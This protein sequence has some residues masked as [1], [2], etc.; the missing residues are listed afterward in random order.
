MNVIKTAVAR[1]FASKPPRR[2]ARRMLDT[3][4]DFT[5]RATNDA[6]G[7]IRVQ[8]SPS[9]VDDTWF[10]PVANV[11]PTDM[12]VRWRMWNATAT[13]EIHEN[14]TKTQMIPRVAA[15]PVNRH[16]IPSLLIELSYSDDDASRTAAEQMRETGSVESV[17]A[18]LV[19][20]V[21][22]MTSVPA[23]A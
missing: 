19:A 8:V 21:N 13:P 7:R 20:Y 23:Y 10:R 5:G 16:G 1:L 17:L 4:K 11:S 6:D 15:E 3:V 22:R 12:P 14:L 18:G 2:A 9:V